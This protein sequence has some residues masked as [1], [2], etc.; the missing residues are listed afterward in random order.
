MRKT[1]KISIAFL[2]SFIMIFTLGVGAYSKVGGSTSQ[3]HVYEDED[4]EIDVND[5]TI[6]EIPID[7]EENQEG[8]EDKNQADE[9]D[10]EGNL[11][12]DSEGNLDE[13]VPGEEQT[14]TS[15]DEVEDKEELPEEENDGVEGEESKEEKEDE[16]KPEDLPDEIE[17]PEDLPEDIVKDEEDTVVEDVYKEEIEEP[18]IGE[19]SIYV[20]VTT[21]KE[22]YEFGD[23]LIYNINL[24]NDGEV[25][26]KNLTIIDDLNGAFSLN[27]LKAGEERTFTKEYQIDSDSNLEEIENNVEVTTEFNEEYLTWNTGFIVEIL[28]EEELAENIPPIEGE[29]EITL[30]AFYYQGMKRMMRRTLSSNL[31]DTIEVDKSAVRTEGC[32]TFEVTLDIFGEP[33]EAPVDVVLVIDRSGSMNEIA[34]WEGWNP[35]SRLYY[36]KKA[37]VNFA[38]RVLGPNGIPG[39]RVSIVSYSGP[40]YINGYGNQNQA[41]T[42]LNLSTNLSSVTN[43]INSISASGGTNTEAGFIEAKN[44]IQNSGNPNSNKVVI[45]FTDGVPTASNGNKYKE[46]T[47]INHAHIQRAIAAGQS[48]HS[49]ANVFTVG[50]FENM[51]TNE[52]NLAEHVLNETQNRGFYESPTAQDLD[53]IFTEIST[54]LGYSATNAVVVDKI[55][56]NFDLVL[57]SLPSGASYDANTREITWNIGTIVDHKQLKYTVKAKPSFPDGPADTNEYANLTY[58]DVNGNTGQTKTFPIPQVDVPAPLSVDLS[59]ASIII[60]DSIDL[61]TGIDSNGENYMTPITGGDGDGTYTYEWRIVGDSNIISTDKNST[62]SPEEDTEYE[63]TV[64]DSNGCIAIATMTVVVEDP[65]GSITIKKVVQNPKDPNQEFDILLKGLNGKEYV[66][67]LKNGESKTI[68]NLELGTYTISEIVPMNYK[69]VGISNE[70]ITLTQENLEDSATVTNKHDNDGWFYDDDKRINTFAGVVPESDSSQESGSENNIDMKMEAVIPNE[71]EEDT[72]N[73]D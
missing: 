1:L 4:P 30:P 70:N 38:G 16:E 63:L 55:G 50:L 40:Q 72:E 21:D 20:D 61:G 8:E 5:S 35:R 42:D 36:A 46:T 32:R 12:E 66:V 45:M 6:G 47:N 19:P 73:I 27:S 68:E 62:V 54:Q 7:E 43:T 58:T 17:K 69:L 48:V 14:E 44:V 29:P 10:S 67:T 34:G 28:V 24:I 22:L 31:T 18:Q 11:E 59:D 15:E 41:S 26:L 71:P 53:Q 57:S 51:S 25:D 49:I 33:Q 65:K 37:A 60:G 3:E 52:R 56:D 23:T 2:L 9:E 13:E 39:S 64:I